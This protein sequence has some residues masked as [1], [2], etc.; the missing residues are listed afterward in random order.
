MTTTTLLP[1]FNDKAHSYSVSVDN[2]ACS[3]TMIWNNRA[4]HFHMSV[5]LA[6]G[7]SVV[8]GMKLAVGHPIQTSQMYSKGLTG[9]FLLT[10][11]STSVADT[12]STREYIADNYVFSYIT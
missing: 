1:L 6:D 8:E 10:P 4:E 12:P 3:I 9:V 2:I 7:T 5:Q 11:V